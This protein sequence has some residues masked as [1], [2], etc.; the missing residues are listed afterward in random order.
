MKSAY[1]WY[2]IH[3][4]ASSVYG[5][6]SKRIAKE[7]Y[8]AERNYWFLVS[9]R[10]THLLEGAFIEKR[11]IKDIILDAQ[12]SEVAVDRVIIEK[13]EFRFQGGMPQF[14]FWGGARMHARFL[15]RIEH[16]L[17]VYTA[18]ERIRFDIERFIHGL[19]EVFLRLEVTALRFDGILLHGR[20]LFSAE[21][22]SSVDVMTDSRAVLGEKRTNKSYAKVVMGSKNIERFEVEIWDSGKVMTSIAPESHEFQAL[23]AIVAHQAANAD[24][25]SR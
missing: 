17:T 25:M 22:R 23:R 3:D 4:A 8:S 14:E 19:R 6:L 12:G 18:C 20:T 21:F 15:S 16:F 24:S 13:M 10:T 1:Y 11:T 2:G 9:T 7:T 5:A